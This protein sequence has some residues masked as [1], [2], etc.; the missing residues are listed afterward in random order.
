[1]K[2]VVIIAAAAALALAGCK[3]EPPTPERMYAISEGVGTAAG[4]AV[5]LSK[6]KQ[7]VKD[8]IT[9]VLNIATNT[10]P[11]TNETFVAKWTPLIAVEVKKLVDAGKIDAAQ[12]E[13]AKGALYVACEGLDL[14]FVRY[15]KA[16]SYENLVSAAVDGF[17]KG[18]NSVMAPTFRAPASVD[19]EALDYLKKKA[20]AKK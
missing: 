2:K 12:G 8:A 14:V 11:G 3:H 19:Q 1:M 4:L 6:T 10:V 9:T 17:V 7:E 20:A 15:P 5:E 16:K 13:L 18:F